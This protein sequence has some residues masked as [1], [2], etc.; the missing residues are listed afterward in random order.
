MRKGQSSPRPRRWLAN[1]IE[2]VAGDPA[3]AKRLADAGRARLRTH[4]SW[5]VI[6]QQWDAVYR[7]VSA[8]LPSA[9]SS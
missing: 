8:G 1:A 9:S 2:R 4:F 5:D 6:T 3:L 7:T